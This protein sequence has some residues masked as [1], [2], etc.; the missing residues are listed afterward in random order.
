MSLGAE[1][2]TLVLTKD[3]TLNTTFGEIAREFGI[4]A[5]KSNDKNGGVPEELGATKYEGLCIDFDTVSQTAPIL[6]S[7]RQNPINRNTVIFAVVGS[8]DSRRRA[9]EQGATFLLDRPLQGEEVRRV[10]QAAYG[11][12]TRERRRYF[13]CAAEMPVKLVRDSGEELNC[14]TINISSNGM[15]LSSPRPLDAAEKLH[16]SLTLPGAGAPIRL[17]GTVVWDDKHGKTGLS[18]ECANSQIQLELDSWLDASFN[19]SIGKAN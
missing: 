12:M 13:R 5:Q 18:M 15:A 16:I 1:I 11:L 3:S 14:K 2:R 17:Q 7:V 19:R 4:L 10:L 6:T 9:R 8:A